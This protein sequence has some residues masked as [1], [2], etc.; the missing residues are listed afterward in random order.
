MLRGWHKGVLR[1]SRLPK[2][3]LPRG[4][5][6]VMQRE[7]TFEFTNPG[8]HPL[9]TVTCKLALE[10]PLTGPDADTYR[11]LQELFLI[12]AVARHETGVDE[13]FAGFCVLKPVS[14]DTER[15][16]LQCVA[17]LPPYLQEV[18]KEREL[19]QPL[20]KETCQLLE[21]T[22]QLNVSD[23]EIKRVLREGQKLVAGQ[24]MG[25]REYFAISFDHGGP[26]KIRMPV[27]YSSMAK[28]A[29]QYRSMTEALIRECL[30]FNRVTRKL[31]QPGQIDGQK[32][33]RQPDISPGESEPLW[34]LLGHNWD[35]GGWCRVRQALYTA[36]AL[37]NQAWRKNIRLLVQSDLGDGQVREIHF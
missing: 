15:D 12:N 34:H 25:E 32:V 24:P 28:M 16:L 19:Q 23:E 35:G 5:Q 13:L 1:Q 8:D 17:K 2:S 21:L 4:E 10:A 7:L 33:T 6:W 3:D 20:N 26:G 27:V 36:N 14:A 30:G 37:A 9:M 29:H 31:I 11:M 18:I 22:F